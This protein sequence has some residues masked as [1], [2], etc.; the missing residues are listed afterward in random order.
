MK[1]WNQLLCNLL[2]RVCFLAYCGT[3][4]R[5]NQMWQHTA[6]STFYFTFAQETFYST[7]IQH[8]LGWSFSSL[9]FLHFRKLTFLKPIDGIRWQLSILLNFPSFVTLWLHLRLVE[10]QIGELLCSASH[11][12]P[13]A[14]IKGLYNYPIVI[15]CT[16]FLMSA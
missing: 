7:I 1:K 8:L 13:I 3:W 14:I 4:N 5:A 15:L 11:S 9:D 2:I 12:E 6:W 16:C 10:S